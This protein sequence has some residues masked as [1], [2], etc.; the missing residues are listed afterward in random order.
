[1]NDS[2]AALL[3]TPSLKTRLASAWDGDVAWSFRHSPIAIASLIV[4]TLCVVAALCA[5]FLAPHNPFDLRTLNLG[6]ART[7][8]FWVEGGKAAFLLGSDDQGR[9][10]FS[11]I[12]FGARVSLLVGL[13]SV[14]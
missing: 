1:M 6:D 4:F 2:A 10:V 11:A 8:P 13:A 3:A 7:P 12:M 5:P 14:A 9:D